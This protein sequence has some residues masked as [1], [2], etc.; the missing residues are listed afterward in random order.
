[1]MSM[2][3]RLS[4]KKNTNNYS[5]YGL[6]YQNQCTKCLKEGTAFCELNFTDESCVNFKSLDDLKYSS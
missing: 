4:M 6:I 3:K 1:M 2:K 5:K